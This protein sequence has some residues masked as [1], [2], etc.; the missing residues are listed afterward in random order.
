[1]RLSE[2]YTVTWSQVHFDRRTI[3]LTKTKNGS[4]RTVHLNANAL[5]AIKSV[6]RPGQRT[7]ERVSPNSFKDFSTRSWFNPCVDEAGI[8][9]YVWHSH[10]HTF[11]SWLSMTGATMKEI[12]E[13]AGHKT[14]V[15][16]AKYAHLSPVHNKG[17]VDRIAGIAQS[18]VS[19]E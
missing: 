9:R 18:R 15:T 6:K 12:Q 2:Q 10:R 4:A 19:T 5:E 3:N 7:S 1:M 8:S 16:S 14:I 17:V 13:V 11:C